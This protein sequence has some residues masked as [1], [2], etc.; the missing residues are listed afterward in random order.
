MSYGHMGVASL[1]SGTPCA[2]MLFKTLPGVHSQRSLG[3]TL[4]W[5]TPHRVVQPSPPGPKNL[6]TASSRPHNHR[7]LTQLSRLL[8]TP[9]IFSLVLGGLSLSRINCGDLSLLQCQGQGAKH[10][11]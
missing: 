9:H 1:A 6:R 2:H 7:A 8:F 5:V 10:L 11:Q 4:R 3:S